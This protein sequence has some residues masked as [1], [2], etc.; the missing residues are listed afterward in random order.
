MLSL[1]LSDRREIREHAC[2]EMLGAAA[3]IALLVA[4]FWPRR[5]P[6]PERAPGTKPSPKGWHLLHTEKGPLTITDW[7]ADVESMR[8]R[9]DLHRIDGV[10]T[11]MR[12]L[13]RK[14]DG[15][16]QEKLDTD[17]ERRLLRQL[18]DRTSDEV[19]KQDIDATLAEL[20]DHPPK[21]RTIKS[22][23]VGQLEALYQ[24]RMHGRT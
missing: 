13:R 20:R 14:P 23:W 16:W 10:A 7:Y 2:M 17:W 18:R 24:V 3:L 19:E 15:V 9:E 12:Y 11:S 4:L 6:P 1:A 22:P 5:R 8:L 21:W